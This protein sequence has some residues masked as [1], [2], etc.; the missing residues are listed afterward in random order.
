MNIPAS[1]QYVAHAVAVN[2]HRSAFPLESIGSGPETTQRGW[3]IERG[4]VGA[5]ADIGGGYAGTQGGDGGDLSDVAL[6]WV[7]NQAELAGVRMRDLNAAQRTVTNPIVHNE[8]AT[9]PFCAPVG[10]A[11]GGGV[12]QD[13]R[14]NGLGS[15]QQRAAPIAGLTTTHAEQRFVRWNANMSQDPACLQQSNQQGTVNM[16]AYRAWLATEYC[17]RLQ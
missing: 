9:W 8:R 12:P 10:G 5:H 17:V 16:D 14:V 1:V 3:R 7:Y 11:P 4:F 2:E 6:N 15:L 13:R